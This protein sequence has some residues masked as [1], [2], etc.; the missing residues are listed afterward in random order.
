MMS[1]TAR[2][3]LTFVGQRGHRDAP[4]AVHLAEHQVVGHEDV[5]E[6]HL[7]ELGLAEHVRQRPHSDAG[8]VHRQQEVRDALV[9]WASAGAGEQDR[10]RGEMGPAGPDLLAPHH[11][12]TVHFSRFGPKRRQVRA[13][14]RL[15]EQLAPDLVARQDRF[16]ETLFLRVRAELNH[17]RPGEVLADS[18]QPLRGARAVGLLVEHRTQLHAGSGPAVLLR[19]RQA[20][21]AR[22]EQHALPLPPKRLLRDE[23][24]RFRPREPG[25]RGPEPGPDLGPELAFLR[26]IHQIHQRTSS[27]SPSGK[28]YYR[29]DHNGRA[30]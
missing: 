6:E 27:W 28:L 15:G 23:V 12:A 1:S 29:S 16:Q 10:V 2:F 30:R 8:T 20:A 22:V 5:V 17:G 11:P 19:P 7:V 9:P 18:V 25:K 14:F 26:R 13:G 21:V 3:V 24:S 4:A